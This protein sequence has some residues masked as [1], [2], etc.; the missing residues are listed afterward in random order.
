MNTDQFEREVL[1][2]VR[3]VRQAVSPALSALNLVVQDPELSRTEAKSGAGNT[4]VA[5][6]IRRAGDIVDVVEF[7]I[8]RNGVPA[9]SVEELERWLRDAF[10]DVLR[11]QRLRD[12]RREGQGEEVVKKHIDP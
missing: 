2:A 7:H 5:M 10:D 4:E 8:Y 6:Y 1:N 3:C 9:A 12:S 11:R